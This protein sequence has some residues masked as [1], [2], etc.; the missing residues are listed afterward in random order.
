MSERHYYV[1]ILTNIIK[2]VFYIGITGNLVKR[3][4]EHK[5]DLVEGF[6]KRYKVHYLIYFE[7]FDDPEEAI[8]REKQ[9]KDW[10]REKKMNL[11]KKVN[12]ELR[13]LYAKII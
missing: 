2:T 8:K 7:I 5:N 12:P 10:R 9:I 1:Y 3:I 11:I 6:T 4:W 13:D